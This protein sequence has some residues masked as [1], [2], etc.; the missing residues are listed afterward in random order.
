M[1]RLWKWV[2]WNLYGRKRI[3]L[4]KHILDH[5]TEP[6]PNLPTD[7]GGPGAKVDFPRLK[8]DSE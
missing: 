3:S 2:L 6:D 5:W 8:R 1:K 4:A 7:G